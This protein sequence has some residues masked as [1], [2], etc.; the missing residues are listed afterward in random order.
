MKYMVYGSLF[1]ELNKL[2]VDNR[3]WMFRQAMERGGGML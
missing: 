2:V 1:L 3:Y